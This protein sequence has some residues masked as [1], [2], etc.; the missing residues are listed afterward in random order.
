MCGSLFLVIP[1][2]Y[3]SSL[4]HLTPREC[5][6]L[7]LG[8]G[9]CSARPSSGV[10][11]LSVH[12]SPLALVCLRLFFCSGLLLSRISFS[13]AT[14]STPPSGT[15]AQTRASIRLIQNFFFASVF[16]LFFGAVFRKASFQ[17]F[18]WRANVVSFFFNLGV[19]SLE[20]FFYVSFFSDSLLLSAQE[21]F[22]LFHAWRTR[23]NPHFDLCSLF[24]GFF[25][26]RVF[27]CFVAHSGMRSSFFFPLFFLEPGFFL[28]FVFFSCVSWPFDRGCAVCLLRL[29]F[30]F[31]LFFFF[32]LS[33]SFCLSPSPSRVP[34]SQRRLASG[35]RKFFIRAPLSRAPADR[36]F[37]LVAW[38]INF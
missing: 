16:E 13:V 5:P 34:F 28:L 29:H 6:S 30:L 35:E 22:W 25:F 21:F 14:R 20:T 27:L 33:S 17:A 7:R 18:F 10:L 26:F 38:P 32:S 37:F 36:S 12:T 23:P 3:L 31:R 1:L 9:K 19:R 2:F 11:V 24:P 8:S 4:L 15:L